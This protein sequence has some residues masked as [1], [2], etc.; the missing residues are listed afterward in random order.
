MTSPTVRLSLI[1]PALDTFDEIKDVLQWIDRQTVRASLEV[2][3]VC[4]TRDHL[5]TVPVSD[6]PLILLEGGADL[7]IY[8]ARV[9]GINASTGTHICIMEDHC[10]PSPTWAEALIRRL[11]EGWTGV[12]SVYQPAN[13]QTCLAQAIHLLTYGEWLSPVPPGEIAYLSGSSSAYRREALQQLDESY[14]H[15]KPAVH[16]AQKDL[17]AAGGTFTV[18]PNAMVHHFDASVW[19]GAFGTLLALGRTLGHCRSTSW[20]TLKKLAFGLA[21]PLVAGA[22]ALRALKAYR[23]AGRANHLSPLSLPLVL[24]L[25]NVWGFGEVWGC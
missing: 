17:R 7:T 23:R 22:H 6:H 5:Q 14:G 16:L 2:V 12:G 9:L 10:F 3:V 19:H 11:E 8:E 25:S 18:E 13:P 1:L 20:P 4:R 15:Q 24:L 21:M